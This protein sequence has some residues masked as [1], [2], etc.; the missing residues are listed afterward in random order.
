[1]KRII[2]VLLLIV[3]MMATVHYAVAED[4]AAMSD[5]ELLNLR[6][7]IN[8][9]LAA[10]YEPPVLP[11]GMTIAE[12]FPDKNLAIYIRDNVGAISIND[13]VTHDDL[14]K[15]KYVQIPEDEYKISSL[16]GIQYLKNMIL[17][18][19]F[20]QKG[21]M[22]IPDCFDAFENLTTVMLRYCD[23]TELPPSIVNCATLKELNIENTAI[24][25]LPEDIGNLSSLKKLDISY[26]KI[27]SLPDSIRLLDLD[28]FYRTGLDLGE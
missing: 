25:S 13:Q 10:R 3:V 18:N 26:T 7:A 4:L 9:E 21:P 19:I 6:M 14:S 8:E 27:T 15:I 20:D 22:F 1:M 16:E 2:S 12:I 5:E 28:E 17:L 24:A 23:I 11:D